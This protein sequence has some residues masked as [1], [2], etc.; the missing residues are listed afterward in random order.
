MC[1]FDSCYPCILK[2]VK[3]IQPTKSNFF[4]NTKVFYKSVFFKN[5]GI[6]LKYNIFFKK[7]FPLGQLFRMKT[8]IKANNNAK[9]EL[10]DLD[11]AELTFNK[12]LNQYKFFFSKIFIN[13]FTKYF[14]FKQY[15]KNVNTIT[16]KTDYNPFLTN[17]INLKYYTTNTLT[18]SNVF[19]FD[20]LFKNQHTFKYKD[21][22]TPTNISSLTATLP[23]DFNILY[24]EPPISYYFTLNIMSM[25]TFELPFLTQSASK[26][27]NVF[28]QMFS[29][30]TLDTIT[31][32]SLYNLS[33][34]SLLHP[35]TTFNNNYKL[36]K[37]TR[38]YN[39]NSTQLNTTQFLLKKVFSRYVIFFKKSAMFFTKKKIFKKKKFLKNRYEIKSFKKIFNYRYFTDL[40]KPTNEKLSFFKK[41]KTLKNTQIVRTFLPKS[42]HVNLKISDISTPYSTTNFY[43][44][45]KPFITINPFI[46]I[47]KYTNSLNYFSLP[48]NILI[49]FITS[50]FFFKKYIFLLKK[51]DFTVFLK[52]NL[53]NIF[54]KNN[55]NLIEYSNFLP[56]KVF[57]FRYFKKVLSFSKDNIFR[58]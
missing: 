53:N 21:N 56:H 6:F 23:I 27:A 32:N 55:I 43:K 42:N 13:R 11:S 28:W 10:L 30:I 57:N 25:D 58:P 33:V 3:I 29:L 12:M 26:E 7:K 20:L 4:K 47:Q 18:F 49:L 45:I 52:T 24:T 50:P 40:K 39:F 48:L 8:F 35:F 38:L 51:N 5:L 9:D 22:E 14:C 16:Y 31:N 2:Q 37:N 46:T 34:I 36:N 54:L 17:K 41:P 15:I 44:N 19:E 1:G